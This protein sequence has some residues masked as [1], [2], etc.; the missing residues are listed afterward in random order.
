MDISAERSQRTYIKLLLGVPVGLIA[1]VFLCWGGVYLYDNFESKHLARR[2]AAYLS[3]GD[4]RQALLSARRSREIKPTAE[5]ARV[6]AQIA[7]RSKEKAALNWRREAVKLAPESADDLVALATCA[8]QFKEI[9]EAEN[10]LAAAKK[11]GET[12]ASHAI[13]GEIADAKENQ[14]D[15]LREWTRAVEMEPGNKSYVLGLALANLRSSVPAN[16]EIGRKSL[17]EIRAD[18]DER[19][20]ATRALVA[21]AISRHATTE[22]LR[23]LAQDL[24]SYPE[25]VFSDRLLY[26]SIL[27]ALDESE[28]ARAL[29][30]TEKDATKRSSD[31]AQ[32]I[33]WM[34]S[35]GTALLAL[36]FAHSLS[37]EVLTKWPVP[38]E[39]ANSYL[40]VADWQGLE[41]FVRTSQWPQL[42][43]IRRAF[44]ARALREQNK[45]VASDREWSAAKQEAGDD[46]RQLETL[47]H[48]VAD[49]GWKKEAIDLLWEMTKF[50]EKQNDA[51]RSLYQHYAKENDTR[52]LY[53]VLIKLVEAMPNDLTIRNNFAQISLLLNADRDRARKLAENLHEREPSNPAYAS[54]YAF[55]VYSNGNPKQAV[56]IMKSLTPEQL[57]DPA[58]SAYLGIFLAAAG[59]KA[60]AQEYL[61]H[62]AKA[63]LLPEEKSL[64][65]RSLAQEIAPP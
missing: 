60:E 3:G 8:L 13:A 2:A 41:Q 33:A 31:L 51:L 4:V 62:G 36:D 23:A 50:P 32:L 59:Q 16:Q 6:L 47:E 37:Q 29:T 43:F 27:H 58:V 22:R 28:F 52:E 48:T 7:E 56:K 65:D 46:S 40:R 1:F 39:L 17:E 19:L 64:L 5:A 26:L 42:D 9:P 21:D 11:N 55:A 30:E 63:A 54:T 12:S 49:W 10:A 35:R 24:Q 61:S 15:A 53:R 45:T 34:N 20:P 14:N 38:V 25:S 44:L 57:Q 18:K